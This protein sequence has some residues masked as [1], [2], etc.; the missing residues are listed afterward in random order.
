VVTLDWHEALRPYTPDPFL[1]AIDRCD[2]LTL[3]GRYAE[4][5]TD[6]DVPRFASSLDSELP[7]MGRAIVV[8]VRT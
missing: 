4:I 6:D 8:L 3:A 5:E 7:V 2:S 1:A